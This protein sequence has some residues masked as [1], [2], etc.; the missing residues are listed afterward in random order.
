MSRSVN[1]DFSDMSAF[2]DKVEQAARGGFKQAMELF[3][4]GLGH[5]FLRI[6]ED[7]IIRRKA[8][9]SRLLLQSFH[10]GDQDNVWE[11]NEGGLTLEVGTNLEYAGYVNDG[12]WTNPK[13]V[14]MRWVPG[15]WEG[16]RFI[17]DASA[18]TGMALKQHWVE[19][20]HYWESGLRILEQ[21]YP[22]L[23]EAKLQ[24][25][26]DEYFGGLGR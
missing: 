4:E 16:D 7:E 8:I 22:K 20:A 25:W 1:V 26:L 13:G 18:K 12:H 2:L 14:K 6:M 3:L 17:H 9:D 19:G 11:M 5:E 24:E 21:I 23:L 15:R 10:K